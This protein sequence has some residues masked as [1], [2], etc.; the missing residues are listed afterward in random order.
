MSEWFENKAFWSEMAPFMFHAD[1]LAGTAKQVDAVLTLVKA[2]PR[3]KIL[4]LCCGPGRH[5]LELARRGFQVTGVDLNDTYIAMASQDAASENLTGV[6]FLTS[7]MRAFR[8]T[9]AFDGILNMFTSFGYFSDPQDDRRVVENV[10][11][12]LKSG[13]WFLLEVKGKEAL[14]KEF[15]QY[16]WYEEPD[17]TKFLQ[18]RTVRPGWDW[19]T[20]K[21]TV[22]QGQ[23]IR[24]HS[25][26]HR[27]YSAVE[28]SALLRAVGFASVEVF[29]DTTGKPYDHTAR[30]LVVLAR[31]E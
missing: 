26:E 10:F 27:L 1:R 7:D 12:G 16:D 17:G 30:Y 5:S 24:E 21:W 19:I 2:E 28:L 29:G 23:E 13:G 11:A 18:A 25:F 15:R 14:A 8:R 4:D 3:C 6:E 31:K 20:T 22:I 9:S